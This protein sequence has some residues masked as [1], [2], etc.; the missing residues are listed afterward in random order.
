MTEVAIQRRTPL[1][2]GEWARELP[3]VIAQ[4]LAQRGITDAAHLDLGARRLPHFEQLHGA[5][6]AA[7]R[8]AEAIAEQQAICICGDFD[9]DG[10]TS[11]ALMVSVLQAMGAQRVG[12]IVPN[13]FADGYGLSPAVVA[14]AQQQGAEL[15]ITVDSGISCHAGVE[16]A[17]AANISV[18]ITD[19]HLPG[20]QLPAADFI[21]NPNQ[22][23]CQFPSGNIA[24]VG[25]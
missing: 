12:Y 21:I 15:I 2:L 16:A 10:A 8:I 20:E 6:N 23:A 4:I 7:E 18:I 14:Q 1:Q 3:P 19:H 9:A 13:R 25:V 17:K 24:G 5:L 22:A 11:T